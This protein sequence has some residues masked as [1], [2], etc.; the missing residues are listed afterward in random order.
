M[1]T[2]YGQIVK[3]T[4]A[5]A[6]TITIEGVTPENYALLAQANGLQPTLNDKGEII[7]WAYIQTESFLNESGDLIDKEYRVDMVAE[8][9]TQHSTP[10]NVI[11]NFTPTSVTTKYKQGGTMVAVDRNEY[12]KSALKIVGVNIDMEEVDP[13]LIGDIWR[14]YEDLTG[15]EDHL[16]PP[17][18]GKATDIESYTDYITDETKYI[19]MRMRQTLTGDVTLMDNAVNLSNVLAIAASLGI[20]TPADL[21]IDDPISKATMQ[22]AQVGDYIL[23]KPPTDEDGQPMSYT[24]SWLGAFI[25][26][27]LIMMIDPNCPV[28]PTEQQLID[29]RNSFFP[30]E[31]VYSLVNGSV[32]SKMGHGVNIY[33]TLANYQPIPDSVSY[34][35]GGT[36]VDDT[37]NFEVRENYP[38]YGYAMIRPHTYSPQASFSRNY[39][40]NFK[41]GNWDGTG[42]YNDTPHQDYRYIYDFESFFAY[43][44]DRIENHGATYNAFSSVPTVYCNC[45]WLPHDKPGITYDPDYIP[46][47]YDDTADDILNMLPTALPDWWNDNDPVN[48]YDPIDDTTPTIIY[49]PVGVGTDTPRTGD[50][51]PPLVTDPYDRVT[52]GGSLP[53]PTPGQQESTPTEPARANKFFTIYNPSGAELDALGGELWDQNVIDLL[54][55][56]FVSPTDGI[57]SYHYLYAPPTVAT[58]KK[59]IMIGNYRSGVTSYVVTNEVIDFPCGEIDVPRLFEDYRDYTETRVLIYLPYIGFQDLDSRDVIGCT[60]SLRYKI[61]VITGTCVATINP[62]K[63]GENNSQ[64]QHCA[65][66]FSGNCAIQ[67][68]I[69]AADRSRLLSGALGGGAAGATIGNKIGSIFPGIGN[70]VGTLV[71]GGL[72]AAVGGAKGFMGETVVSNGFSSNAG[73]LCGYYSP[74]ILIQRSRPADSEQFAFFEGQPAQK[75][76]KIANVSGFIRVKECYIDIPQAS[77]SEK[78]LIKTLLRQGVRV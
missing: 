68:P 43:V 38:S 34:E 33:Q 25:R 3:G 75:L 7:G 20:T 21:F 11:V 71:G 61:D 51:W 67:R 66:M 16:T 18:F 30:N 29:M 32:S 57:I 17:V 59:N 28:V 12:L 6:P 9:D 37:I 27:F 49:V 39:M 53:S 1:P 35:M 47:N 22:Q 14:Y 41:M 44:K 60:V 70:I 13:Q 78:E 74:Y 45:S 31:P 24:E 19:W 26:L 62:K 15:V 10:T 42:G 52:I 77:D 73:A 23:L 36:Y 4:T 72:G 40:Q 48:N 64:V 46:I 63:G 65:Y 69:T 55:Q 56:T 8:K 50:P 2:T 54:K 5:D 58:T 76:V